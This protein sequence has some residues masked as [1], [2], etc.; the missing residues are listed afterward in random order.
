MYTLPEKIKDIIDKLK[1]EYEHEDDY[2]LTHEERKYIVQALQ[3][4]YKVWNEE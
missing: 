3:E 4:T 1:L 2:L